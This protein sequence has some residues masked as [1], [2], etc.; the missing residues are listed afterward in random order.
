MG[1][2]SRFGPLRKVVRLKRYGRK[3]L[4]IVH[5]SEALRD[6]PRLLLTDARHWESG[7]VIETWSYRWDLGNLS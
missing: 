7:R 1:R 3:R 2:R 5:D 4:V 6:A